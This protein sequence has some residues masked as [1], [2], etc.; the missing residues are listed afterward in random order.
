MILVKHWFRRHCKYGPIASIS[1]RATVN[2][3]WLM[4]LV[5]HWFRRHCKYGPIASISTRATVK[6]KIEIKRPQDNHWNRL[7]H[8]DATP[9]LNTPVDNMLVGLELN[10]IRFRTLSI[11]FN[12]I[13]L[14]LESW[15][16]HS[17]RIIKTKL[18]DP[19]QSNPS[20]SSCAIGT[21]CRSKNNN[22]SNS[23][24]KWNRKKLEA[25]WN[26]MDGWMDGWIG[27]RPFCG[28]FFSLYQE[29]SELLNGINK[30]APDV[31]NGFIWILAIAVIGLGYHQRGNSMVGAY[32]AFCWL[33][34]EGRR[35][36]T[37]D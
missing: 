30:E 32:L 19:I 26:S 35:P 16:D 36:A 27:D 21:I 18:F 15:Y 9:I 20:I 1:T 6:V 10:W 13:Q 3:N 29:R 37:R 2:F 12:W 11:E 5:K 31:T 28:A 7:E 24:R 23:K 25:N 17:D 22:R 4:I 34:W 8:L 14:I 33:W